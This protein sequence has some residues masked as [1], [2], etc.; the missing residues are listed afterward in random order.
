[1]VRRNL[2]QPCAGVNCCRGAVHTCLLE[3]PTVG[4]KTLNG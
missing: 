1:M 2:P 4:P 3:G